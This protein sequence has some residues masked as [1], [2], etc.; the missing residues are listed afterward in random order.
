[1]NTRGGYENRSLM[2]LNKRGLRGAFALLLLLPV[3]ARAGGVVTNCTEAALR[4]AMTGGGV[5]TFACDGTIA[6]S[7]PLDISTDTV[8]D[9]TNRNVTISGNNSVRLVYVATNVSLTI[10]NLALANGLSTNGGALF[11]AGGSVNATNCLFTGNRAAGSDGTTNAPN[12]LN[13]AGGAVCNAGSFNASQCT[14][15]LNAAQGGRGADEIPSPWHNLPRRETEAGGQAARFA[16]WAWQPSNAAYLPATLWWVARE[17]LARPQ[18]S[19]SSLG[20]K[21]LSEAKAALVP[22]EP[23]IT[24]AQPSSS[25]AR[26]LPMEG[27]VATAAREAT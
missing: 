25:T 26:S 9:A 10:L 11:N 15:V 7:S 12:G 2:K 18:I 1:M 3:A 6:L 19:I 4:A 20:P 23:C 16:T 13:G 14:F 17:G 24:R 22:E 21:P 5:V 27:M 8:L